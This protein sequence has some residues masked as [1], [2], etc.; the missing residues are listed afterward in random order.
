[1]LQLE[2]VPALRAEIAELAR[3]R[4]AIVLAHNY[5][6]RDLQS[7]VRDLGE[8][9]RVGDSLQLA[10][11]GRDAEQ[12]LIAFCGVHF[13]AE[14]ASI[15]SPEKRVLLPDHEA[16]C[17]LADSIT[18][19]ALQ[20]WKNEFPDGIVVMYVNTT[21]AVKALT[22]WCVTSSN[23]V[24]VTRHLL[25]T[26]GLDQTVLFGPDQYLGAFVKRTLQ[27]EY[28]RKLPNLRVWLGECHV[29][30]GITAGDIATTREQNPGADF[31]VHPEC[32][33][34]TSVLEGVAAGEISPDGLHLLSTGQMLDHVRAN[35]TGRF[36]VATEGNMLAG[37]EN[38]APEA[39]FVLANRKAFCGYMAMITLTKLRDALL[40]NDDRYVV[41]V[42]DATAAAARLPI[43]RMVS[44]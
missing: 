13:M 9:G 6:N 4:D 42:D 33:C 35:P 24:A 12:A 39:E 29:H 40:T 16:G 23:A 10:R 28:G 30:A 37:L 25:E 11:W 38:E 32:G 26:H 36:V 22:D 1:M 15:L 3:E 34:Q 19:E 5:M 14:S 17:S 43:E 44:L 7:L 41:R 31:L 8:R 27:N 20:A 2:N 21:A 18:P